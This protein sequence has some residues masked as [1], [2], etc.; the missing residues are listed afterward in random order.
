MIGGVPEERRL[1]DTGLAADHQDGALTL[2]N[3]CHDLVERFALAGPLETRKGRVA[4]VS[5]AR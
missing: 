4:A 2:A 5:Q 1:S 3:V